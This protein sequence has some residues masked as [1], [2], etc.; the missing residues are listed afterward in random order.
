MFLYIHFA[1]LAILMNWYYQVPLLQMSLSFLFYLTPWFRWRIIQGVHWLAMCIW[2]KACLWWNWDM[3][4]GLW[5][6]SRL[7]CLCSLNWWIQGFLSS[8]G[9]HLCWHTC[10]RKRTF[11]VCEIWFVLVQLIY[12]MYYGSKFMINLW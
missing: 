12:L 10:I 5:F 7:C 3:Q 6:T 2:H 9:Q 1:I 11:L 8:Q 4:G